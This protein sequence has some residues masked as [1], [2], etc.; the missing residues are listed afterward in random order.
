MHLSHSSQGYCDGIFTIA[1]VVFN[2]N[3]VYYCMAIDSFNRMFYFHCSTG[4]GELDRGPVGDSS[5]LPDSTTQTLAPGRVP[6]SL[7]DASGSNLGTDGMQS[8]SG[9]QSST[10]AAAATD[11]MQLLRVHERRGLGSHGPKTALCMVIF[12]F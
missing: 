6:T 12:P 4:L 8:A 3:E 1:C 5:S 2:A 10:A 7:L 11:I 9:Q